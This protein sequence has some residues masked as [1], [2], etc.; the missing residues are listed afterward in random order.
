MTIRRKPRPSAPQKP[1]AI[2]RQNVWRRS[3]LLEDLKRDVV[4]KYLQTL[5]PE[6]ILSSSSDGGCCGNCNYDN[7]S[8][9]DTTSYMAI[10]WQELENDEEFQKRQ[11]YYQKVL[12]QYQKDYAVYEKKLADWKVWL[13]N[14]K[15]ALEAEKEAKTQKEILRLEQEAAAAQKRLDAVQ[16]QLNAKKSC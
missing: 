9:S 5:P 13:E 11:D 4:I 12:R 10:S 16:K 8:C 6:A 2:K 15:E 3:P 1:E 14:N 7:G